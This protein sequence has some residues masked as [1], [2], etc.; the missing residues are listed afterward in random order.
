MAHYPQSG[1]FTQ[2][3]LEAL[4]AARPELADQLR[5]AF[6]ASQE[7][8]VVVTRSGELS[9]RIGSITLHSLRDPRL[10]AKR[11]IEQSGRQ[12]SCYVLEGFGMGF[13]AETLLSR[14]PTTEILVVEPDIPLFLAVA[15]C[16]NLADVLS[17]PRISYILGTDSVD[18][19]SDILQHVDATD[20]RIVRFRPLYERHRHH[21][22]AVDRTIETFVGRTQVN[23]NTLVRFGRLWVRNLTRNLPL[24]LGANRMSALE[25]TCA[26]VPGLLLGAGPS[27]D[28]ILPHLAEL[29]CKCIIVA[30]DTSLAACRR[31]GVEP[32]FVVVVDPQYWNTRHLDAAEGAL[33]PLISESSTHPRVFRLL[34][35]NLFFCGSLFP[36]GEYIET[37]L[38]EMGKLGA[39]GSVSTSAWDFLRNLGCN[40]VYT[41]GLDLG[42]PGKQTHF[43]GSFFENRIL[44]IGFRLKPVEDHSFH[45]LHDAGLFMVPDNSGEPVATDK[46]MVIYRTWFEGQFRRFPQTETRSLSPHSVHLEGADYAPLDQILAQDDLAAEVRIRLS[47]TRT[48]GRMRGPSTAALSPGTLRN[49]V[50]SLIVD[51]EQI[52]R[53]AKRGIEL[54]TI[55]EATLS[56]DGALGGLFSALDDVDR[57]LGAHRSRDI[58]G[59]LMQEQARSLAS[60]STEAVTSEL[61]VENSRRIYAGL[62]DSCRFHRNCL[63]IGMERLESAESAS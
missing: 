54:V 30:V 42:F 39:G 24:F 53:L 4:S 36:L 6:S 27:L 41:A 16:R 38:G 32:D 21:F 15:G 5:N 59:F 11:L 19:V 29:S 8:E 57:A 17:S 37:Q 60:Q 2:L 48:I 35:G 9:G 1:S 25:G 26:G 10:E 56:A 34:K 12:G 13:V 63:I 44:S 47:D 22:E 33:T 51:L 43:R 58:A 40:P 62:I 7:L 45:Y 23:Q 14:F 28:G 18:A 50:G 3:N 61:V 49:A 55:A 31:A 52:E 46:R 20:I